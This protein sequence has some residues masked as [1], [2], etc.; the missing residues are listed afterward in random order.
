MRVSQT[1]L[2]ETHLGWNEHTLHSRRSPLIFKR[3]EVSSLFSLFGRNT[4]L[5]R[6]NPTDIIV[7]ATSSGSQV[8]KT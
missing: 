3:I 2:V 5:E 4:L 8:S 7:S 6:K 1:Y